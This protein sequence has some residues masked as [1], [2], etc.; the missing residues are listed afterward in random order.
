MD[1]PRIPNSKDQSITET[2][3]LMNEAQKYMHEPTGPV[4]YGLVVN[5]VI[6]FGSSVN[7]PSRFVFWGNAKL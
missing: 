3:K 6:G 1:I 5:G 7:Y 2:K 4:F